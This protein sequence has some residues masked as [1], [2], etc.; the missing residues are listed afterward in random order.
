MGG[1]VGGGMGGMGMGMG[2]RRHVLYGNLRGACRSG[3]PERARE[4]VL[5][6]VHQLDAAHHLASGIS[7]TAAAIE[8]PHLTQGWF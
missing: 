1:E 8:P 2:T 6:G 5:G 4:A 3:L 7:E